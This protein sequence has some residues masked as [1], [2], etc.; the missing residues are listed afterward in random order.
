MITIAITTPAILFSTVSLVHIGYTNR[1]IALSNL[2][3]GL[4][5]RFIQNQDDLIIQQISN[6]RKR[7]LLIR[8]MQLMGIFSLFLSIGSIFCLFGE[9]DWWGSVLFVLSLI[10]LLLSVIIAAFEIWISME[11]L[12]IELQTIQALNEE[13]AQESK[14]GG[15]FNKLTKFFGSGSPEE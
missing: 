8:N 13:I 3:R 10:F 4:K 7:I 11:A 12:Q 5:D 14:L 2:V 15:G 9:L 1:F 6:L